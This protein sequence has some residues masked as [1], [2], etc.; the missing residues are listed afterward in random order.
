MKEKL[1]QVEKLFIEQGLLRFSPLVEIEKELP[2]SEFLMKLINVWNRLNHTFKA[3][4]RIFDEFHAETE[5]DKHR[6]IEDIFRITKY[7]KHE[8]TLEEIVT[9]LFDLWQE[10]KLY[11]LYCGHIKRVTFFPCKH[12]YGN[13]LTMEHEVMNDYIEDLSGISVKDYKRHFVKKIP[14]FYDNE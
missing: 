11:S 3:K 7:Y 2:L 6:S 8:V 4:G 10:K 1:E 13:N 14:S 12:L 9:T 5:K